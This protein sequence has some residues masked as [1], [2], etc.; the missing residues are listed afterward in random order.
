MDRETCSV[1]MRREKSTDWRL[2]SSPCG[3]LLLGASDGVLVCCDWRLAWERS[4]SSTALEELLAPPADA[5]N[6]AV[7][8]EA[9]S[10]LSAYF[11]GERRFF[12]L[13]YRVEGTAFQRSVWQAIG[14]ISYGKTS[15]YGALAEVIGRTKAFR[16]VG[17]ATGA[18]QLSIIVPCHRVVG[19]TGSFSGYRGGRLVKEYLLD[20]EARYREGREVIHFPEAEGLG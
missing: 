1:S 10:Q 13:P 20:L 6:E 3:D 12:D 4:V 15:T 5:V 9:V 11:L 7:L 19:T 18:N 16:A 17:A 14:L 2:Y 8:T